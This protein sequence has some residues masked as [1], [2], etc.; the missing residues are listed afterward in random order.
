MWISYLLLLFWF[1]CIILINSIEGDTNS[2]PRFYYTGE[3]T[4][5][6]DS[7]L[8][9]LSYYQGEWE[10]IKKEEGFGETYS[11]VFAW[12]CTQSSCPDRCYTANKF[13]IVEN[14]TIESIVV[15]DENDQASK[16]SCESSLSPTNISDYRTIDQLYDMIISWVDQCLNPIDSDSEPCMIIELIL[17]RTFLFPMAVKL[18]QGPSFIQWEIPCFQPADYSETGQLEPNRDEGD[19]CQYTQSDPE[20]NYIY[21]CVIYDIYIYYILYI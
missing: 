13:L 15:A 16:T 18:D 2:W 12:D 11:F 4:A 6:T 1:E 8:S 7:I 10:D 21:K 17:H 3:T 14:D 5:P 19:V 20:V 9:N